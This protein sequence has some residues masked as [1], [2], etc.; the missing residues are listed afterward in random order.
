MVLFYSWRSYRIQACRICGVV[1]A[2]EALNATMI[3]GWWGIFAFL[4]NTVAVASNV[5]AWARFRALDTPPPAADQLARRARLVQRPGVWVTAAV[6]LS[7][8]WLFATAA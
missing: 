5:V 1:V 7:T 6:V 3:K 8:F 2:E 4:A